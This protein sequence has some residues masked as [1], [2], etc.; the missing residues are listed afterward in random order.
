MRTFPDVQ[1]R[2]LLAAAAETGGALDQEDYARA[3]EKAQALAAST[4]RYGWRPCWLSWV[5]AVS[6]DMTGNLEAA[7][8][9]I[10][11]AMEMDPFNPLAQQSYDIIA[12]KARDRLARADA[13]DDEVPVLYRL[14]QRADEADVPSHLAMARHLAATGRALEAEALLAAVTLT[15]PA[16]RDA[17]RE[18]ARV[19]RQLGRD[20][21]A[22]E[23]EA[24]AQVR[25]RDDVPFGLPSGGGES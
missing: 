23:C 10:E 21:V 17:W 19:A 4:R 8:D 22:A 14:L 9:H 16:S 6:H 2:K 18:R 15:A 5:Q 12:G 3:L 25:G 24:E 1:M 7:F 20:T 11:R 13:K